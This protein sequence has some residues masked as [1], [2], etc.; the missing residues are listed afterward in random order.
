[1]KLFLGN[2][3]DIKAERSMK[4]KKSTSK[5][6]H[7]ETWQVKIRN[8][9]KTNIEVV[10]IEKFYGFWDVKESNTEY[11]KVDASTLHFLVNVPK[12]KEAVLTYTISYPKR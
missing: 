9:K 7:E 3:F 6:S 5:R 11:K 4:D 1:V 12:D 2:A 8:H 10:V